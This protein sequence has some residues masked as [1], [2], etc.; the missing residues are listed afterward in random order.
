MSSK[1]GCRV[2][3]WIERGGQRFLKASQQDIYQILLL[4]VG[5]TD[6]LRQYS[7]TEAYWQ[8]VQ[9]IL[10]CFFSATERAEMCAELID[11][12]LFLGDPA[13]RYFLH[14]ARA[15][16]RCRELIAMVNE[17]GDIRAAIRSIG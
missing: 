5:A 9:T 10:D 2:I 11:D 12:P 13:F 7:G 17:A 15:E 1:N 4:H 14:Q 3:E 16:L 8:N 6:R